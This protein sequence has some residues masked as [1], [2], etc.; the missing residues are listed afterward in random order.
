MVFFSH[1]WFKEKVRLHVRLHIRLSSTAAA[2]SFGAG[3]SVCAQ[4]MREDV[5][6][7]DRLPSNKRY[8]SMKHVLSIHLMHHLHG[9]C[10]VLSSWGWPLYLTHFLFW[11]I[12][13]H[14]LNDWWY[15]HVLRLDLISRDFKYQFFFNSLRHL[16]GN[17]WGKRVIGIGGNL[18]TREEHCEHPCIS[19]GET[20]VGGLCPS[21]D[22]QRG[23]K[24]WQHSNVRCWAHNS[25]RTG[26][27]QP[28]PVTGL[29]GSPIPRKAT[30]LIKKVCEYSRC[31]SV[32]KSCLT[33]WDLMDCCT[34]GSFVLYYLPAFAQNYLHWVGAAIWPPH[35]LL[36]TS[37]FCLLSF[38]ASG[39]FPGEFPVCCDP[40]SYEYY[41]FI[42]QSRR[43]KFFPVCFDK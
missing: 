3:E 4:P 28:I 23:D 29:E 9:F 18:W 16:P 35:P 7:C 2:S 6:D 11:L 24:S 30:L 36:P 33:L 32:A 39:S 34:P 1:S 17:S 27:P 26:L 15:A 43:N 21:G 13:L 40:H 14:P 10:N 25:T 37:P 12:V 5:T 8:C 31:C 20:S 38:P 42:T 22:L 19:R 41:E